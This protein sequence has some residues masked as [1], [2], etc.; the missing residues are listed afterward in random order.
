[1][2]FNTFYWPEKSSTYQLL[3]IMYATVHAGSRR[4]EYNPGTKLCH[5]PAFVTQFWYP[6]SGFGTGGVV[7]ALEE[8]FW[9]PLPCLKDQNKK[10]DGNGPISCFVSYFP[11]WCYFVLVL[12]KWKWPPK[13]LLGCQNLVTKGGKC[14]DLVPGLHWYRWGPVRR[15]RAKT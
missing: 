6:R 1:M 2:Q 15:K 7:L 12:Q 9:Q 4:Y 14:H 13:P 3:C 10:V 8:R 5:P 11:P